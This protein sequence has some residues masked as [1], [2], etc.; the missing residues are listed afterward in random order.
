[1]ICGE[2][3]NDSYTVYESKFVGHGASSNDIIELESEDEFKAFLEY[4][5]VNYITANTYYLPVYLEVKTASTIQAEMNRMIDLLTCAQWIYTTSFNSSGNYSTYCICN[6]TYSGFIYDTYGEK[7][8][9]TA[10]NYTQLD[11]FVDY[12]YSGDRDVTFDDFKYK[13][14]PNSMSVTTS[15]QLFYALEH[16]FLPVPTSGSYADEMLSAAKVILRSI[17]NDSMDDVEKLWAIY[18]WFA[19]EIYYDYAALELT[20]GQH[21]FDAWYLEGVFNNHK[22][23]CDGIAKAFTVLASMEGIACVRVVSENHAWN[24]AAV[25]ADGDGVRE[26]YIIDATWANAG[27]GINSTNYEAFSIDDFL[28][29]DAQRVNDGQ[30]ALNYV[31]L[32]A[33]TTYVSYSNV[34][35]EYAS[36]TYDLVIESYDELRT[37]L[38]ECCDE[39]N[40]LSSHTDY[41]TVEFIISYVQTTTELSTALTNAIGAANSLYYTDTNFAACTHSY[42]ANDYVDG[43]GYIV[44]LYLDW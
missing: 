32:D 6:G 29:T 25:D 5:N 21:M 44:T 27:I 40:D 13:T 39:K 17:C 41:V 12:K 38:Y 11:S 15:D 18:N 8:T 1:M 24:K 7:Y 4:I 33:G 42:S 26:W 35:F 23:V 2:W 37:L 34:T 43:T 3:H 30:I 9:A 14:Y 10:K 16:G 31:E 19:D 36:I 28:F 22:A 20:T